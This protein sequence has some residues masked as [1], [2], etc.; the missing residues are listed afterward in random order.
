MTCLTPK[1]YLKWILGYLHVREEKKLDEKLQATM[2][3]P[4]K[5][6]EEV[7]KLSKF[8][9]K[10]SKEAKAEQELE[11]VTTNLRFAEAKVEYNSGIGAC[12]NLFC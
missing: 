5:I 6:Q 9:K 4:A 8:P 7:K 1:P 11:V 10:D 2:E 12:Y 3:I